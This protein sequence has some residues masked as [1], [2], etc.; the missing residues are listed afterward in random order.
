MTC[1]CD[2]TTWTQK[3][4]R[5]CRHY[6]AGMYQFCTK[7]YHDEACHVRQPKKPRKEKVKDENRSKA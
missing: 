1:K 7:C 2:P 5:I 6:V 4:V 3:P